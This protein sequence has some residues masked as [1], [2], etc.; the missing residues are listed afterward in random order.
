M[1]GIWTTPLLAQAAGPSTGMVF[2]VLFLVFVVP[3]VLGRLLAQLLRLKEYA[4]PL[5]VVLFAIVLSLAPFLYQEIGGRPWS[6]ALQ[7]GID[8]AGGTNLIYAVDRQQ[9]EADGKTI[10]RATLDK[11][12]GAVGRRINPSGAEEVVVRRVGE[13]RIEVIVPGADAELVAQKK[14]LIVNLGS[15]EFAILANDKDHARLIEAGR[16]LR[17]NQDNVTEGGRV[18]ASWRTVA[19][20]KDIGAGGG[21]R[22]A[23][24]EVERTIEGEN[25]KVLQFLVV[26]EP[27]DRAVTGKYLTR[28]APSL[29]EQGQLA[30][31]FNFNNRGGN[32]FSALTGRYQPDSTDGFRRR[33]GVLLNGELH[34]APNLN[35]RISFNG[36]I[37]GQFTKAEVD[38]LLNV[39]NAGALEVPLQQ[40]PISEFTISPLLGVDVQTKGM[41]AIVASALVVFVFMLVYYAIAGVVANLCLLLNLLLVVGSMAFIEATFTLPGLAGLVLTIGMAVD[42]NVL[43]YERMRE[44]L[45]RG[46]SLRMAIE[47]GFEKAFSAIID[48]NVTTLLTAVILYLIGTDQIRGFAV[49]LFIG[50]SMSLFSTLYFGHLCFNI[51][52]KKRW[53]KTIWMQKIIGATSIDFLKQWPYA[54]VLSL[55]VIGAGMAALFARGVDNL[56]I[57]FTGGTMVTFEF[58]DEQKT[59]AVQSQLNEAFGS[60]VS[61]ERLVMSG[62]AATAEAG[63][64]FRMR[65]T[66]A[67]QAEVT[68][69]INQALT[70]ANMPLIK[71]SLEFAAPVAIPAVAEAEL[72]KADDEAIRFAGGHSSVLTFSSSLGPATVASYL[73]EVLEQLKGPDG[74]AKYTDAESLLAVSGQAAAEQP[75]NATAPS[76]FTAFVAKVN[77]QVP[78]E[79]LSAALTQL[80]STLADSPSFE[81]VNAF[82]TSVSNETKLD[83]LLAIFLSLV[84]IVVY[85]WYRFENLSFGFAAVVALVHDVLVTLACVALAATLSNTFIGNLLLFDDFKI[86]L[87]LVA[88]LLTIVGYSINDTIVIF[89]RLREIKGKNPQISADMINASVNQT[90]SRTLLTALTTFMVVF[91]L[92]VAGGDGIHGFAFSMLIGVITGCYSTVYIAN[93]VLLWLVKRQQAKKAATAKPS[94]SSLSPSAS[95]A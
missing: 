11:L 85:I 43:I 70:A 8:L 23:F 26:H 69:R 20:G 49:S 16:K 62:E 39:L 95:R 36:Q 34:T 17:D 61:L 1:S 77:S 25:K 13:D 38:E 4:T 87:A 29:D 12:V 28:A 14:R 7:K 73:A 42:S 88:S 78:A 57:D 46:A 32:L 82:D 80:Q 10:D 93:P 64:R 45:A 54:A 65:T 68:K 94:M 22:T 92:Y 86:N 84:M 58:V 48:S 60:N 3:F 37:S 47:N 75:E 89:D 19:Q 50:L 30:V 63:H 27:A 55:G 51:M 91:V 59:A 53:V 79:D 66:M 72:S 6:S 83:A 71:V 18:V 24:R 33:L 2:L 81:E 90:L 31:S 5:G 41:T 52:E 44:E 40:Q 74:A 56:D 35:D 15:L 76:K 21:D 67:D 9:A